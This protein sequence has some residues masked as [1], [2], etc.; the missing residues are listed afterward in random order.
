MT[1]KIV[2]TADNH[3]GRH[4]ARMPI[5]VLDA[6][7]RRIRRALGQV[8]DHA[9]ENRADLLLLAGDLFDTPNP[10]NSER[11]Y[12]ARQLRE[13]YR[14][15]VRVA[16]IAGNHDAPRSSTEEGGY[17][18]LAIYQ[19]LE[20]LRLYEQLGSDLLIEPDVYELKGMRIALGAFT[21]SSNLA[22]GQDPLEGMTYADVNADLR[23]LMVHAG[24]EGKMYEGNEGVV[25]L[26]TLQSLNNVD[27]L[28][29]GNV[30]CYEYFRVGKTH[31]VIPGATEWMNFGD[32]RSTKPGFAEI[33]IS[34]SQDI[35]V[36]HIIIEPQSR[37]EIVLKTANID[38]EDPTSTVVAHLKQ[39]A[40]RE[41]L[42]RLRIEGTLTRAAYAKLNLGMIE[43]HARDLFF[44]CDF[45]LTN[46]RVQYDNGAVRGPS[47]RR[48]AK[49]EINHVVD[50][51]LKSASDDIER[52]YLEDTRRA[53][54]SEL[55]QLER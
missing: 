48:S 15:G 52:E 53:L 2:A 16:A 9:K 10:R 40:D 35:S 36:R 49:E 41:K 47:I 54:Q 44:F 50:D 55:Q 31:V 43:D 22:P 26:N 29:A 30:H 21:P 51:L 3:L 32:S 13:L 12:L 4:Y 5:R 42:A 7:R 20:A 6:R 25:G 18:A 19:E 14:S 23:I 17:L 11:L 24:I 27:L 1:L 8:F 28:I 38:P 39:E 46:L 33:E 37:S 45:D 34:Q